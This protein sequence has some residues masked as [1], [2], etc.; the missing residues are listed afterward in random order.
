MIRFLPSPSM[1][2]LSPLQGSKKWL[3][4]LRTQGGAALALG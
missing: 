2:V 1:Q 3:W 4:D